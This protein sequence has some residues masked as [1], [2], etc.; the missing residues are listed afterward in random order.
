MPLEAE[1]T[2][3]TG[4]VAG[5]DPRHLDPSSPIEIG[6]ALAGAELV[7]VGARPSSSFRR[8]DFRAQDCEQSRTPSSDGRQASSAC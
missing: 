4:L 7:R 8:N 5:S 2:A 6:V 3:G 1:P